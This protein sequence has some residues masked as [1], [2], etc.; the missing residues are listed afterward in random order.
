MAPGESEAQAARMLAEE[1]AA[2]FGLDAA[3]VEL[4]KAAAL[5]RF[6]HEATATQ[7]IATSSGDFAIARSAMTSRA[8]CGSRSASSRRAG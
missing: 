4:A 3:A 8:T 5:E 6:E 2:N 7:Y 1:L